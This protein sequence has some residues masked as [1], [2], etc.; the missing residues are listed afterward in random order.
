MSFPTI[1][2]LV[3]AAVST[4]YW[5]AAS[6]CMAAFRRRRVHRATFAPHVTVLKPVCG[7]GGHL[8]ESLRSFCAQEYADYQIVVGVRDAD[9]P[10]VT[11]VCRLMAEYP[12]LDLRLVV[13]QCVSVLRQRR[14]VP[15]NEPNDFAVSTPDQLISQFKQITGGITGAMVFIAALS[16]LIGGVGVMNIMLVSV[17]ERT[18]EIG[19]RKS[20]GAFRRDI[21]GQF[22]IEAVTLSLVGGVL[23]IVLG[24]AGTKLTTLIAGWPTIISGNVI[25]IAFFFSL[26]VG[27][28]F[29]LYPASKASR[30]N[31][32]EALRYE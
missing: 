23:G 21:V 10:A 9:D 30:L 26:A 5:L 4:V 18:R 19:I 7:A 13:D 20:L 32:I 2:L 31:P 11:V 15:F 17:T 12:Q 16:L 1:G 28:F 24:V 22:L 27:L 3:L 8:Y 6:W 29:G 14:K 25:G